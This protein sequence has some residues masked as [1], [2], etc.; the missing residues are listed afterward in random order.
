MLSPQCP[1]YIHCMWSIQWGRVFLIQSLITIELKLYF[2]YGM[3][4]PRSCITSLKKVLLVLSG[5]LSIDCHDLFFMSLLF[6][7]VC[8]YVHTDMSVT[9]YTCFGLLVAQIHLKSAILFVCGCT[10]SQR[11]QT[12]A[13]NPGCPGTTTQVNTLTYL[14][15]CYQCIIVCFDLTLKQQG[16][17]H[18]FLGGYAFA[19][20]MYLDTL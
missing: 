1:V 16:K 4:T 13:F 19:K 2:L 12:L 7:F 11:K 17:G 9:S 20:S 3:W 18:V 5:L 14:F 15:K 8:I 6:L 10:T